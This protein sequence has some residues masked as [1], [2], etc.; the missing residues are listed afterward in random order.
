MLDFSGLTFLLS[1]TLLEDVLWKSRFCLFILCSLLLIDFLQPLLHLELEPENLKY[2]RRVTSIG[3]SMTKYL[4]VIRD[5]GL[6]RGFE[7]YT[8]NPEGG[9]GGGGEAQVVGKE[10]DCI[11]LDEDRE[12]EVQFL[13][14]GKN[15]SLPP[16]PGPFTC[17]LNL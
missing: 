3:L 6:E 5:A 7:H 11:I 17:N 1:P 14:H 16:P 13:G 12:E 2:K 8:P 10:K 9:S 15:L 4:H